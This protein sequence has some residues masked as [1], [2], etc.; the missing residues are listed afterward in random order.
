MK[1]PRD[2]LRGE[3]GTAGGA[4]SART[5]SPGDTHLLPQIEVGESWRSATARG[6][7]VAFV[8][9]ARDTFCAEPC[10]RLS[11]VT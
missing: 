11:A 3:A 6:L 10:R 4:A 9:A 8:G 1:L 7:P 5:G 2:A